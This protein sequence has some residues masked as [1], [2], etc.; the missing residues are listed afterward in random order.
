MRVDAPTLRWIKISGTPRVAEEAPSTDCKGHR[1]ALVSRRINRARSHEVRHAGATDGQAAK[2]LRDVSVRRCAN[3]LERERP[4]VDFLNAI[5]GAKGY[6]PHGY[7]FTWTPGLLWSMV[8]ADAVIAGAYFSIPLAIVSFVRRRG[9]ESTNWVPWLFSAFIFACGITHVMD[10]WTIWSPD[11]A[12]QALTKTVT[13]GLSIVTAIALWVLIPKALQAPTVGRLQGVISQLEEEIRKRRSA[14]EHLIDLQQSLALTLESI[15]AGFL[16]TDRHGQVS[17]MN[18]VTER[19]LG[20][21]EAEAKGKIL[22]NVMRREGRPD[23]DIAMNPVDV[24]LRDGYTV[25]QATRVTVVS[26]TGT[27]TDVEVKAALTRQDDGSVRGIA[28]IIRDMTREIAAED[29]SARLAAI[30][31]SSSDAIIGTALDGRITNWNPA[32]TRLFGYTADE[33]TGQPIQMLIPPDRTEEE[34]R[35][36]AR[37]AGGESASHFETVRRRKDGTLVD[38]STTISPVLDASGGVVG[39]SKIA[40][41]FTERKQVEARLLAQLQR[42]RLLDQVTRSVGE[43]LDVASVY[44]VAVRNLADELPADLACVLTHSAGSNELLVG[45]VGH[46]TDGDVLTESGTVVVDGNGLARCLAGELVY[47]SNTANVPFPFAQRLASAG[48]LSLVVAPLQ[49]EGQIFGVLLAARKAAGSFAS[50]ECEFIRQLSSHVALAAHQAKLYGAL[51][52]AFDELHRTQQTAVQQERLRALGQMASGIAHDINNALSPAV[53]YAE[54]LLEREALSDRAR[55]YVQSIA[56]SV[57]DVAATVARLR[58]FYRSGASQMKTMPLSMNALVEQVVEL[59][60]ARWSDMP[61]QRGVVIDVATELAQ[62]LPLV[63]G[64][65]GEIRDALVNLVFNAVDAMPAGGTLTLRTRLASEASPQRVIVEVQDTGTGMDE[66]TRRHCLEP[67]FTTKG[68]RGTGLGL[69]MVYG[70][71][72]RH[73]ADIRIESEEGVGSVFGIHFQIGAQPPREDAKPA[74]IGPVERMRILLVDDDP[75]LLRSLHDTLQTDGQETAT[76]NGGQAGIDAFTA[77]AAAGRPF[78]LVI[79]DLGMP[80]VDG[81]SVAAAVKR[82]SPSTPVILLTGWGQRMIED[83]EAPEHVDVVLSKPPRLADLRKGLAK[84]R[85]GGDA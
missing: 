10:V 64:V 66:S 4:I 67:F 2:R 15:G 20:W 68:E 73:G 21:T 41:D 48:Y 44:Q 61:L 45:S 40:R 53:L 62:D 82:H 23:S 27:R 26:R 8:G 49:S 6:L 11:Y 75:A 36:L 80:H 25:D 5:F 38:V 39:A 63:G 37:I 78:D 47:E 81:R 14:E 28:L 51:Q 52:S 43:R 29:T 79:T 65:E 57:D 30:V 18:A 33:A 42:L 1:K 7:C 16:A 46:L 70:A 77:A 76:A 83:G 54:N 56:R 22:W 55:A 74:P 17:R 3:A 50:G 85:R 13:A 32:A 12:L 24:M 34:T 9:E 59:T 84:C 69:S 58:E 71:A 19:L 31:Q 35:I 72:Q 60:R